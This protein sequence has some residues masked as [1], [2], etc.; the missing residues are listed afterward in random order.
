MDSV[1]QLSDRCRQRLA[2]ERLL[3][4]STDGYSNNDGVGNGDGN[5][6][7]DADGAGG[8]SDDF[9]DDS[10]RSAQMGHHEDVQKLLI[11]PEI[12]IPRERR[13]QTPRGMSCQLM[14]H[15]KVC[16]TWLLQQEEDKHK[17]GG[18]LADTMGLGKTIQA[19]ALILSRPSRDPLCKT[20]L[21]VAPLALLRQWEQEIFSKVK[22]HYE[23]RTVIFH[24]PK[25]K[26]M[27]VTHLLEHDVVLCTY[28]K[29]QHEYK[30]KH[31]RKK[32][33]ELRIL[34]RH[35]AFYRVIL[36]EAHNIKNKDTLASKAAAE[37]QSQSR[38]CMTG[39]PFMN[40][41]RELFPLIRFLHISPY[42]DWQKFC[43][44]IDTPMRKW[45][46][47]ENQA[48][49]LKLQA[50]FRS[51][52]LRRTK[53]SR[54]D[55]NPIIELP[56]RKEK[57][58]QAMFD[59]DQRAFYHALETK[60]RLKFN[61]Y[62]KAGSVMKN[63]AYI[64]VLLLRLRQVC[65]HPFLIKNHGIPEG[66]KL[67]A[68]D[69]IILA[70]KLPGDIVAR[71]KAQDTFQCPLCEE[72][73]KGPVIVHPC[74]HHIC[75]ECF[76]ASMAVR[77]SEGI[78]EDGEGGEG[79]HDDGRHQAISCPHYGCDN[80]ITPSN[81]L[82][83]NFFI[84]AHMAGGSEDGPVDDGTNEDAS[85]HDD[86]VDENGNLRGFVVGTEDGAS[87]AHGESGGEDD[88][89]EW[90]PRYGDCMAPQ[91]TDTGGISTRSPSPS[92]DSSYPGVGSINLA[93]GAVSVDEISANKI[94]DYGDKA[95]PETLTSDDSSSE[96]SLSS[97]VT[98]NDWRLGELEK[99]KR[100]VKALNS[101]AIGDR[102]NATNIKLQARPPKRKR[103][104]GQALGTSRK[105]P[106]NVSQDTEFCIRNR[107]SNAEG[108]IP[109]PSGSRGPNEA[110]AG[111]KGGGKKK[112]KGQ[113][114]DK[115]FLSLGEMKRVA[116]SSAAAMYRYKQ[117]LRKEWVSSCKID[118]TMEILEDIRKH[119]PEEKTLVFSLWTSFLD[120]LEIPIEDAGIN[121]TRYDGSMKFDARD[122]AVR[123]FMS[124]PDVKIML[125]SL[126]AGNA[127]L[128][129]TAASQVIIL[130]PFWNPY[131]EEQ[132]IDRAH[133]IGQEREVTVHRVL[134]A[135][136]VEDR[137]L[138]LQEQ[139]KFL[140]N[141]ALSE[142][143]AQSVSRL[144]VQE[145]RKLFGV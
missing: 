57:P 133:R 14:E 142:K 69:M 93:D 47:D 39:T 26:K 119:N 9:V 77:E 29:L 51:I 18:L 41:S 37:I 17:K 46:G 73:T 128:N 118:K 100:L 105:K 122:A 80:E 40:R 126:T 102:V 25:A 121:Y 96:N 66:T 16:L 76:T 32:T 95:L 60:Q 109:Q 85:D 1:N 31:E 101:K 52:T 53:D 83:H 49:L 6:G 137:I 19:L 68:E 143:G 103:S 94:S 62:L 106:P 92:T 82:C 84:E 75:P 130:E 63:Y 117:H 34:H 30:T 59:D 55:G 129:L 111:S 74:G 43:E 36:D 4:S 42:H 64:L 89:A 139:K 70:C 50:L 28:G 65:D 38:L 8:N 123:S 61:K 145:L 79:D 5:T 7:A 141:A 87:V 112:S 15:Q 21:I 107:Q 98:T 116:Q 131:V 134:I 11:L 90:E 136:T 72:D 91:T 3:A 12:D 56:A 88:D 2:A 54:I 58:A 144:G 115:N 78:S 35:A 140:V 110:R 135:N 104:A 23:L 27:M 124:N 132:A 81:I 20:T 113:R 44:E 22:P 67:G 97:D 13:K 127:G 71:I 33:S 45:D 10:I 24:G 114:R 120:L 99:L 48:G 138:R 125:V 108:A 86:E